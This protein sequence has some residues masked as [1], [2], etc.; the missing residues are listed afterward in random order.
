LRE[1]SSQEGNEQSEINHYEERE[2]SDSRDLSILWNQDVQ[3]WKELR[4]I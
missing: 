3:D 2:A 4:S 1:V